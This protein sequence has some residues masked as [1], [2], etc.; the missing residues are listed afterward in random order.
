M[1][2]KI[3]STI[4]E[5]V[6]GKKEEER[7]IERMERMIWERRQQL[8]AQRA[9]TRL[10]VMRRMPSNLI[11]YL[12]V[13]TN[14]LQTSEG[15]YR[16]A[17]QAGLKDRADKIL[18]EKEDH[19]KK[20]F[21][22]G[23]ISDIFD[24]LN[25][26]QYGV[27]GMLKGKSFAEGVKNRESWTDDDALGEYGLPGIIAG[28]ILDIA[29]DPLTYIAPITI[30]KKIP[31]VSKAF[32]GLKEAIFGKMVLKTVDETANIE[33]LASG[34]G[35]VS[36]KLPAGIRKTEQAKKLIKHYTVEGGTRWGQWIARKLV[37]MFG[38]DPVFRRLYERSI[39]NIGISAMKFRELVDPVIKIDPKVLRKI[40][41]INPETL[42]VERIPLKQLKKAVPEL[43]SDQ[44]KAIK[45]LYDWFEKQIQRLVKL[46]LIP[47][48]LAEETIHKYI[49][50][51]Y[52]EYELG[53]GKGIWAFVKKLGIRRLYMRKRKR[54]EELA[55]GYLKSTPIE[56]VKKI[57][58]KV[59]SK[60][61][62]ITL[63]NLTED[64]IRDLASRYLLKLKRIEDPTYLMYKGYLNMVRDAEN[65]ELFH[66][67][68]QRFASDVMH[69]GFK[70]LP[71][72]PSRL[73]PLAGKY[74]PEFIHDYIQEIARP[75]EDTISRRLVAGFKFAKVILNPPTHGRNIAS[76]SVLNWWKVGMNPLSPKT[77]KAYTLAAKEIK[78]PGKFFKEAVK[79][80]FSAS[81][82]VAQE[83][84]ELLLG[85]EAKM[86]MSK[87]GRASKEVVDKLSNLYQKEEQFAKMAA[88][89]YNRMFRK[90]KPAEAWRI[91]EAATFN[92]AQ[93]TPFI[94]RL[95]ESIWGLPFITFAYKAA[96][97]AVETA[98]RYPRRI[99]IFQKVR[100]AI[101]NYAG[102][103]E[104]EKERLVEPSWIRDGFYIKLPMKDKHGRSVYFDLTY[105]LPFGDLISGQLIDREI[106]RETGLPEGLPMAF[107]D[108]APLLNFLKEI[109]R[110]QDFYGDKIWKESDPVALQLGDLVRH[111]TKT[112]FP[113]LIGNE[114]PGGWTR[115]GTR[116]TKG[117][118]RFTKKEDQTRQQR[119]LLQEMLGVIGAKVY[120]I[121]LDI[122]VTYKEWE[123]KRALETLLLESNALKEFRRTYIPD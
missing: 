120:P 47:R 11:Q 100:R 12:P 55:I 59:V 68:S 113:P 25:I 79:E 42:R 21:S 82:F 27:V 80:G 41:R 98:L 62:K 1:A 114:I 24:V 29:S 37:Y 28:T 85:P 49:T 84:R 107:L 70:Q 14:D 43:T 87:L 52:L 112:Y 4:K 116:R 2:L 66:E 48:E 106:S 118:L 115:E 77:W 60:T 117:F 103:E 94:R 78:K 101:E 61:G 122:Q 95:R 54:I 22:G 67:V 86:V 89:I 90:L 8:E 83:I 26:F 74:V 39:K 91:A 65:L 108:K 31:F 71:N 7:P 99:S 110:N 102:I 19:A 81:T 105:I 18:R 15:L 72:N 9:Q 45:N 35:K 109:A 123:K 75:I 69:E 63:K 17:V 97:V 50:N 64:E 93:V 20:I 36:K 13:K 88:Y 57:Y 30:L 96:P 56:E 32:K 58:P 23:W 73:G 33:K 51:A 76:N 121:D 46:G 5:W 38:A 53:K 3:F 16:V 40:V 111:M 92:Y 10:E 34:L 44:F 104:T 6:T 119:T